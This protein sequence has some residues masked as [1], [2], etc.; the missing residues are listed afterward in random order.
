MVA[1][2]LLALV[3]VAAMMLGVSQWLVEQPPWAL[4]L[5][6]GAAALAAFVYGAAFIGQGLGAEQMYTLRSLVDQA[7]EAARTRQAP[8]G[9]GEPK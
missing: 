7:V 4:L 6:P 8:E 2:G 3:G 1:Y 5:V 9:T